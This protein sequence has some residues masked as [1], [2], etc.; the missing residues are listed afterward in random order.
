V[1]ELLLVLGSALDMIK[2]ESKMTI[3]DV[4]IEVPL[5]SSTTNI[6]SIHFIPQ[7]ADQAD[8]KILAVAY[9]WVPTP[10]CCDP[11]L[12]ATVEW[13]WCISGNAKTSRMQR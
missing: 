8:A 1:A 3:N 12:L 10:H 6:A 5:V 9:K 2:T 13:Q 11:Q 7:N 4:D